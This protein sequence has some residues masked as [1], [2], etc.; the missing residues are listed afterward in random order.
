MA[1]LARHFFKTGL[2]FAISLNV[3]GRESLC[4]YVKRDSTVS[5]LLQLKHASVGPQYGCGMQVL[6]A[7]F[8]A[9]VTAPNRQCAM[10]RI[11]CLALV[12]CSSV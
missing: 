6:L 10:A 8:S 5:S 7:S 11:F 4:R 2:H 1:W 3:R 12:M 9:T